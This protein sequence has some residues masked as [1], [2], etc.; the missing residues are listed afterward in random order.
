M[1]VI[2]EAECEAWIA[3]KLHGAFSWTSV[4]SRHS[5][6]ATYLMPADTGRKTALAR[7]LSALIHGPD[8]SLL[9]ITQ[10]GVFPSSENMALFQGYRR[11]LNENRALA[12]APGHIFGSSDLEELECV[13]DLVLYFFWD[14][15]LFGPGGVWVRVS[16][17]EV[18]SVNASDRA[19]LTEWQETLAPFELKC[20]SVITH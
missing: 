1:R 3:S 6:V 8:E 13:L 5:Y 4:E 17:D 2:L 16:H 7:T 15:S 12:S 19:V 20:L 9:W 14:A 11:S 10:S 18:F